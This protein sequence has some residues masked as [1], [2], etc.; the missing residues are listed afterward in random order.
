MKPMDFRQVNEMR[1]ALNAENLKYG[2]R[3]EAL[4]PEKVPR[5]THLGVWRSRDFLVQAFP[6]ADGI[7]R[8]SIN[9]TKVLPDG[10]WTDRWLP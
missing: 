10:H 6:E 2:H 5:E 7:V 1:K 8:L 4:P 9:R 3:L